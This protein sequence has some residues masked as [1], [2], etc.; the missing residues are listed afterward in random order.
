MTGIHIR[1]LAVG[2]EVR[3]FSREICSL[4]GDH[5]KEIYRAMEFHELYLQTS[6]NQL[7]I[8]YKNKKC[9]FLTNNNVVEKRL[10]LG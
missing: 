5:L 9:R 2:V 10:I 7:H 8:C 3:Y 4:K 1:N 6:M